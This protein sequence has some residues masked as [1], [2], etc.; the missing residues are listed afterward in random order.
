MSMVRYAY[1]IYFG[2]AKAEGSE[3]GAKLK[4]NSST[5]HGIHYFDDIN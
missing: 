4:L 2:I 3:G 1:F 5:I